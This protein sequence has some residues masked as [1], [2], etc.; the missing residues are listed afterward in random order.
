MKQVFFKHKE[1]QVPNV[2]TKDWRWSVRY[3]FPARTRQN[4]VARDLTIFAKTHVLCPACLV[5][6]Q[7][8]SFLISSKIIGKYVFMFVDFYGR[9]DCS[10]TSL[11]IFHGSCVLWPRGEGI[12]LHFFRTPWVYSTQET[13]IRTY[14]SLI[15]SPF[16]R[17]WTYEVYTVDLLVCLKRGSL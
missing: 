17:I 9:K 12:L 13:R 5:Q 15:I 8:S 16:L 10:T 2:W 11:R 4:Y 3:Q 6:R 14:L 1:T 7:K